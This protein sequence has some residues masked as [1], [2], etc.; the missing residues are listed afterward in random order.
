MRVR[1]WMPK[2]CAWP[3]DCMSAPGRKQ[4]QSRHIQH[5]EVLPLTFQH[6]CFRGLKFGFGQCSAILEIEELLEFICNG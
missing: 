6:T 1:Q 2:E 3:I 5:V 4:S